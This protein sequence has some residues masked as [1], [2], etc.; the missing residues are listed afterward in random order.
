MYTSCVVGQP[1]WNPLSEGSGH[2]LLWI[3]RTRR[4]LDAMRLGA[5]DLPVGASTRH[6]VVAGE[7]SPELPVDVAITDPAGRV[8]RR[9]GVGERGEIF[10]VRP[11]GYIGLRTRIDDPS[12]LRDYMA[13][14]YGTAA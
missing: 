5:A 8:A 4:E 14:L 1:H 10:A 3:A 9:Y 13:A 11:D 6:V 2:T 12:R 7:K